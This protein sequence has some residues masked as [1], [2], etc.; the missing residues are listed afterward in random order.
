MAPGV[1]GHRRL[2]A[3]LGNGYVRAYG[4]IF[5][6]AI[7]G[8]AIVQARLP[9]SPAPAPVVDTSPA[10]PRTVVSLKLPPASQLRVDFRKLPPADSDDMS[11]VVD[12]QRLPKISG[13]G[14][15]P[16]IAY[17]RRFDAAG[18]AARV[19]LL[20]INLGADEALTSRA[21]DE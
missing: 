13:T 6:L 16:W 9:D 17:S 12:G 19:G 8:A 10:R 14:W 18:P 15:M 21:I 5:V 7:V 20:M 11:E 4:L 1:T 3:F 2:P